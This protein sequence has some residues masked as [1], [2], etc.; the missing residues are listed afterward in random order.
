MKG[1]HYAYKNETYSVLDK[2][3]MKCRASGL[4]FKAVTYFNINKPDL[5]IFVREIEDFKNKFKVIQ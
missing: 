4:W 5:G 3:R 2:A 1:L